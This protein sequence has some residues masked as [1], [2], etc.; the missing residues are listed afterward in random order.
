MRLEFEF[1]DGSTAV[2]EGDDLAGIA[3]C[4]ETTTLNPVLVRDGVREYRVF[5]FA[6]LPQETTV[7]E[8]KA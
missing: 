3:I 8:T 1:C 4:H 5:Q 6:P 7:P 2:I